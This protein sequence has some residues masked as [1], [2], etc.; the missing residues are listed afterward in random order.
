MNGERTAAERRAALRTATLQLVVGVVA[1]DA[2][3][4]AIYYFGGVAHG[5]TQAKQIFTGVWV[6][7]T[8]VT[9]AFLLKRVRAIRYSR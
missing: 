2:V 7:A 5:S 8:A 3:A 4:L 6:V 9:V 1:L